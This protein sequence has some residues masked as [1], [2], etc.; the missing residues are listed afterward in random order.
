MD[1]VEVKRSRG[2]CGREEKS[3]RELWQEAGHLETTGHIY[4]G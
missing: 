4:M 1:L 2:L 3:I